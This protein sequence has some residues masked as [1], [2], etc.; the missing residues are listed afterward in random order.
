MRCSAGTAAA[1][2]HAPVMV[3]IGATLAL[4][5][6]GALALVFGVGLSRRVPR[7][8]MRFVALTACLVMSIHAAMSIRI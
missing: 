8:A 3:W 5:T 2:S 1:R 6:K 4:V 7:K